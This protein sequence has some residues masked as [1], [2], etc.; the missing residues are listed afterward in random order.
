M[1]NK[2][3]RETKRT[4]SDTKLALH[5]VSAPARPE[6]LVPSTAVAK[7]GFLVAPG[8]QAVQLGV[9]ARQVLIWSQRPGSSRRPSA[10]PAMTGWRAER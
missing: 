9:A 3:I 8:R 2:E 6:Q 1:G 5:D 7:L 4:D 10:Q